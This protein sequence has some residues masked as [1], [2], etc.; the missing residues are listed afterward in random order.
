MSVLRGFIRKN[1]MEKY[2]FWGSELRR[3]LSQYRSNWPQEGDEE[4]GS[5]VCLGAL[6][7]A[8][9]L[10]YLFIFFGG[11]SRIHRSQAKK[12][13]S[14]LGSKASWVT[15]S[16]GGV[17]SNKISPRQWPTLKLAR[18]PPTIQD[19][20][21]EEM[22][23]EL[24]KSIKVGLEPQRFGRVLDRK[25]L[26]FRPH[27]IPKKMLTCFKDAWHLFRK[28]SISKVRFPPLKIQLLFGQ[29]FTEEQEQ[30]IGAEAGH[31]FPNW[32]IPVLQVYR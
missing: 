15:Q 8:F 25:P 6:G 10:F 22:E 4:P 27:A 12:N 20:R 16:S 32:L 14:F 30:R 31:S 29:A 11:R 23:V 24:Q 26:V 28:R 9:T 5:S 1:P 3:Q 19:E 18:C 2:R 17:S 21:L 7:K 13:T